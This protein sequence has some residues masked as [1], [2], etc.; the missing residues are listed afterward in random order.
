MT[1]SSKTTPAAPQTRFYSASELIG[2][3]K[4]FVRAVIYQPRPTNGKQVS[5]CLRKRGYPIVKKYHKNCMRTGIFSEGFYFPF[6][7]SYV[8]RNIAYPPASV[9]MLS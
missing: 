4:N 3:N 9:V 7:T 1:E 5:R 6:E 8:F 2:C